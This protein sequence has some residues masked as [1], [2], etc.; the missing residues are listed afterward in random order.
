VVFKLLQDA[1]AAFTP[2]YW[3]FWIGLVL[4]AIV[5]LGRERIQ[6]G[7]LYLPRRLGRMVGWAGSA[8]EP[9]EEAP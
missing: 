2:Q 1:L 9:G 4:V 8:G 6:H 3:Q 7:V 5:L